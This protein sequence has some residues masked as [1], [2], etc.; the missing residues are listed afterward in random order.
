MS[1]AHLLSQPDVRRF[2]V[3]ERRVELKSYRR[4]DG[5]WDLEASLQDVRSETID[6]SSRQYDAGVPI[7]LL[8][9]RVTVDE[10]LNI[11]AA[12]YGAGRVPFPGTCDAISNMLSGLVGVNLLDNFRRHVG[13]VFS[14]KERCTHVS[15]LLLQVPTL[16]IQTIVAAKSSGE[17]PDDSRPMKVDACRAWRSD[18][19]LVHKHYPKWYKRPSSSEDWG[20]Q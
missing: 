10:D 8:A 9:V 16:A 14:R 19:E 15:E 20:I 2:S 5:L 1:A 4:N 3:H 7:H 11:V 6:V 13:L 18:G 17:S 12:S